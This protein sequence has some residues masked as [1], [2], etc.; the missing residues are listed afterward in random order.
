MS[1]PHL[2]EVRMLLCR[3]YPLKKPV[4]VALHCG[5]AIHA[6]LQAFHLARWRGEDD[7]AEA[8][9]TAFDE[10]FV[11]L[12]RDD[13]A[14]ADLTGDAKVTFDA[15]DRIDHDLG[16]DASPPFTPLGR[17]P[18]ARRVSPSPSNPALLFVTASCSPGPP[19]PR[20]PVTVWPTACAPSPTTVAA[21]RPS[22]MV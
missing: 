5:K 2:E 14:A 22:P 13:L 18:S 11:A 9:A 6:G 21:V 12:D 16:H 20:R 19:L 7:S 1:C 17:G 8:V 3:A 4:P 15:G 10:A